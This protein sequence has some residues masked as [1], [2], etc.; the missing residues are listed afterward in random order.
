MTLRRLDAEIVVGDGS[1][2]PPPAPDER[3]ARVRW[4]KRPGVS[5]FELYAMAL[6]SARGEVVALTED[7]A[8]PRPGWV[9]AIAARPRRAIPRPPRSAARSRTARL[10]RLIEWASYF[11]TQGPHMAPLGDR[12]CP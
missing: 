10:T 12:V 7:H 4:L 6:G 3:P 11:T 1:D 9:A 5:V 8:L 2:N